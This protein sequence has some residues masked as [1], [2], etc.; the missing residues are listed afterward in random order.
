MNLFGSI[1][2]FRRVI[3]SLVFVVTRL[4]KGTMGEDMT[5]LPEAHG[6]DVVKA[7]VDRITASCVFPE[8]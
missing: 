4:S 7:P 3:L 8:D 1:L 6:P 5:I 2:D